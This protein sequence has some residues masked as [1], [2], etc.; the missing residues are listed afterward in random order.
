MSHLILPNGLRP[1]E[2][3]D[4]SEGDMAW[5]ALGQDVLAK[6]STLTI[7]CRRCLSNGNRHGAV[8]RG[9]NDPNDPVLTVECDC[10]RIRLRKRAG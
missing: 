10:T 7:A 4:M 1:K 9:N 3:I 2:S 6:F 8:L 5:F